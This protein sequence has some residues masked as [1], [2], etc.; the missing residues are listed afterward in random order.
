MPL[1][2]GSC[3]LFN[4]MG[5]FQESEPEERPRLLVIGCG[6]AGI[7]IVRNLWQE[8]DLTLVEPKDYYEYTPGILRGLCDEQHLETLQVPLSEALAGFQLRHV[9]GKAWRR[10]FGGSLKFG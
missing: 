7:Q 6:P 9:R 8:F 2:G 3:R 5:W 10:P 4:P 1:R